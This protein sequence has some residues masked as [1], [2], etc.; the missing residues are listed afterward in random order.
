MYV[1]WSFAR[2]VPRS[3]ALAVCARRGMLPAFLLGALLA[4]ARV[5]AFDLT[6]EAGTIDGEPVSVA[7]TDRAAG[8]VAA[9][10]W[11][12]MDGIV[13]TAVRS[14]CTERIHALLAEADGLDPVA[15]RARVWRTT[16][17]AADEVAAYARG[18]T[19][20][21]DIADGDGDADLAGIAHA[22]HV[23]AYREK[24]ARA[25]ERML[26]EDLVWQ[27]GAPQEQPTGEPKLPANLAT[28]VGRPI[29]AQEARRYAAA[30]LYDR[31]AELVTA[32]CAQFDTDAPAP[33]VLAHI[34]AREGRTP[35]QLLAE[36]EGSA[37][38]IP[39]A[40]VE[41]EALDRFGRNDDAS[42]A[43]ARGD[44]DARRRADRRRAWLE[45]VRRES[46]ARCE[47]PVPPAP[48]GDVRSHGISAGAPGALP[49]YY[50]GNFACPHCVS[51][52]QT[53]RQT[54]SAH[55][56]AVRVEFRHHLPETD[57][58][59]FNQALEVECTAAQ[60]RFWA[61]GD[62]RVSTAPQPVPGAVLQ[63]EGVDPVAL[64][65]CMAD[66]RTAVEVLD[67]TADALRLGFR[68]A[69]PSWVVGERIRR[70]DL[71]QTQIDRDIAEQSVKAADG[72]ARTGAAVGA[73]DR[74]GAAPDKP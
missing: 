36:V 65:S 71:S 12:A 40:E 35:E 61:Y 38:D 29:T 74:K 6:S 24:L 53:L 31:E 55:E 1:T 51:G 25:A 19:P 68:E 50:F 32:L 14:L 54:L 44:I 56:K 28:C 70:G 8:N 41:R 47:L 67:D 5:E 23:R 43:A 18:Q 48:V 52:W 63:L 27:I 4:C 64:A 66:A 60:G 2:L 21:P 9:A 59:L 69:V 13:R 33:L 17:P 30:P 37:A 73:S 16:E 15:W 20:G 34:A 57:V 45:K 10:A 62:W 22:M 42:L 39:A 7:E 49:V 46:R 58:A 11:Q 3:L 26:S 72:K